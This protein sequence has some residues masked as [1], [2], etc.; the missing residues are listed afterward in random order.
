MSKFVDLTGQK[1][2]RLTVIERAENKGKH[3]LWRCKCDCGEICLAAGTHLKSG[4][5]QSCGCLLR[6]HAKGLSKK[7]NVTHGLSES[8]IYRTY[9]SMKQRCYNPNIKSYKDY[10]GRGIT[11][12]A[13]WLNDFSAFYEWAMANGYAD[14]LTIDRKD[15]NGNYEPSNCRW[16]TRKEQN[17]NKRNNKEITYKG[18]TH[19]MAGWIEILKAEQRKQNN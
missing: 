6:E 9:I 5:K 1:F 3:L 13:E 18:E 7:V 16:A 4:S 14:D 2:G 17:N 8:R 19:T 10:G 12:C 15:V 11:V